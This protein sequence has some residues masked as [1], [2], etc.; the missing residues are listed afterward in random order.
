M[1][2]SARWD[3]YSDIL[4][5]SMVLNPTRSDFPP[6]VGSS[7]P[8]EVK[9]VGGVPGLEMREIILPY[10]GEMIRRQRCDNVL[11]SGIRPL[12][13]HPTLRTAD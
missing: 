9:E 11:W 12:K 7:S 13:P 1:R 10:L 3:Q 8:T 5:V 6:A 4:C 2:C